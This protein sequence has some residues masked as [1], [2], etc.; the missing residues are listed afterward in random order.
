M[1]KHSLDFWLTSEDLPDPDN[2]VTLDSRRRHRPQLHAEQRRGPRPA[3]GPAAPAGAGPAALLGARR[4]V[5][6]RAVRPEPVRRPA[7]PA[8]RRRAPERHGPL[9]P[10]PDDLGARRALP[11]ARRRQPLRRGR[12]LLPVERRGQPGADDHRQRAARR[13]SPAR[14]GSARRRPRG[15]PVRRAPRRGRGGAAARR[16]WSSPVVPVARAASGDRVAVEAVAIG[17]H[18]GAD[19]AA[20]TALLRRR[21]RLRRRGRPADRAVGPSLRAAARACSGRGPGWRRCASATSGSSSPSTWR[22][23]AG[24]IPA[25]TRGNDRWFQ[26]IAIITSD[27]DR[28]LRAAARARRGPRLHRPAAAAGLER[29]RCRHPRVLLPRPRW[30]LPRG[31][32]VPGRQGRRRAGRP[33]DALFLGID[34]TAIVVGRHRRVTRLLSR[35]PRADDRRRRARTTARNRST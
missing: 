27:M 17:R 10:R 23:A 19:L 22:R 12:Q 18:H 13:R 14:T 2:R 29:R 31:A 4:L 32:A 9:R 1:A 30:P 20:S 6:R 34:H 33:R 7:H 25:D 21:A 35:R 5:P 15:W 16:C 26:H 24:P 8:G 11:G 3:A 28:G